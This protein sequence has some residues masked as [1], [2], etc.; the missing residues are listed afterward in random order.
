MQNSSPLVS[1]LIP[2]Y[3][4]STWIEETIQS[5]KQQIWPSIEIVIVDDGSTDNTLSIVKKFEGPNV[6]IISQLNKGAA[7][8][9][10]TALAVSSGEFIQYL[11]ADD[12]LAPDKISLQMEVLLNNGADVI[13]SSSWALFKDSLDNGVTSPNK[14]WQNFDEPV[15]W[16]LTAWTESIWLPVMSWLTP[17]HL[18]QSAGPWNESLSL[19]DDGEFFSRVLLASKRIVFC[20]KAYSFYRKGITTS[21][22]QQRSE[23]AIQSHYTICELS[24]K[25]LLDFENSP[26]TMNACAANYQNFIYSHY[27]EYKEYLKRAEKAVHRLGGTNMAPVGS[28]RFKMLSTFLGWKMARKVEKFIYRNNLN[29]RALKEKLKFK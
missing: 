29:P 23:K 7:A 10:N 4:S 13:S 27:P 8:A 9:R 19:H 3:N 6:K 21:L 15:E 2:A 17:R 16:L 14:L 11:D 28:P 20:E 22:S 26:R 12:L 18:I 24:E 25:H 1:I 5:I